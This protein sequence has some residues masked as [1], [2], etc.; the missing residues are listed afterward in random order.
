MKTNNNCYCLPTELF[1]KE[2]SN[3]SVKS[4][5]LFSMVLTEAENGASINE[6]AEL[7]ETIGTRKVSSIYSQ[8]QKEL[9]K[10]QQEKEV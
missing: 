4:K 6:L 3:F 2:Y 8:I 5:V 7:I 10:H 1:S 9:I